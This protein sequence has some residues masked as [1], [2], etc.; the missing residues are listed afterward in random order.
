ME[1]CDLMKYRR[2]IFSER[3]RT[4]IEDDL[5]EEDSTLSNTKHGGR[6]GL[7]FG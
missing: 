2:V 4:K 3:R 5:K 7:R 1:L 6:G